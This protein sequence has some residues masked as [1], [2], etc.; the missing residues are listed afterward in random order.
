M[1]GVLYVGWEEI[2]GAQRT[3]CQLR[4]A[5]IPFRFITN[6]TT[7]TPMDLLRKLKGIGLQVEDKD[8]FT[9]VTARRQFLDI[10]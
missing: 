1:D 10:R 6:T 3:I 2:P 8:Q 5:G 4:S 7:R 9:A